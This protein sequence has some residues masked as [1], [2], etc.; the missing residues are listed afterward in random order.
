MITTLIPPLAIGAD[1]IVVIIGPPVMY[2]F[3]I[4]ELDKKKVPHENIVVSLGGGRGPGG[5]RS[6]RPVLVELLLEPRAEFV[7]VSKDTG[8]P[9]AV[10][11]MDG[12]AKLLLPAHT[13][14]R[15]PP[16]KGGNFLPGLE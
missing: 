5:T 4:L 15:I 1:T 7:L 8:A 10:E 11:A 6:V 13:R 2:K 9:R 3:V 16:Q 14:P 12:Q